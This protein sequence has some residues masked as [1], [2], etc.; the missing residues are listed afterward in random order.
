MHGRPKIKLWNSLAPERAEHSSIIER[1]AMQAE[2]DTVDQKI[3]EYMAEHLGEMYEGTISGM[4]FGG[5]FVRLDNSAEG[6]VP[7]QGMDDYYVFSEEQML[8]QGEHS[9]RVFCHR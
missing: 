4:T 5:M 2:R 8:V 3:A 1:V 7:Y 9:R 6:M